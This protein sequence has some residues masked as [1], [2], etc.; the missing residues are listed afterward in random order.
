MTIKARNY[1]LN[2]LISLG[3]MGYG[4]IDGQMKFVVAAII[5]AIL[6]VAQSL[7]DLRQDMNSKGDLP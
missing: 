4:I 3:L 5:P 2:A 1:A 7:D 6:S